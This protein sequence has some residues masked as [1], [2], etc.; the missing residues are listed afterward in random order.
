MAQ[1]LPTHRIW[2]TLFG[3]LLV[4]LFTISATGEPLNLLNPV[5]S[6][7]EE[8][9]ISKASFAPTGD[10]VIYIT[11][12]DSKGGGLVLLRDVPTGKLQCVW[13]SR[14]TAMDASFSPLGNEVAVVLSQSIAKHVQPRNLGN[15]DEY[16]VNTYSV[17]TCNPIQ[18]FKI[19]SNGVL[20]V[21]Y[22][23][24][25][26]YLVGT[27]LPRVF[28]ARLDESEKIQWIVTNPLRD[29]RWLRMFKDY[30]G[31]LALETSPGFVSIYA[32]A[33]DLRERRKSQ[34]RPRGSWP[35]AFSLIPDLSLDE[36]RLVYGS[37]IGSP[38]DWKESQAIVRDMKS[39]TETHSWSIG[40]G[41]FTRVLKF[42]PPTSKSVLSISCDGKLKVHNLRSS[43]VQY[44][45]TLDIGIC[46][47]FEATGFSS[48]GT[49]LLVAGANLQKGGS[50]STLS[51]FNTNEI[52]DRLV[53]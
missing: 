2:Q 34:V 48:D 19:K 27:K 40:K 28:F 16:L 24:D 44:G 14:G 41:P 20:S 49:K 39:L 13:D 37:S 10:A 46:P 1:K 36:Q 53:P 17:E 21:G 15:L 12:E 5:W 7:D 4:F 51:M 8:V 45:G 11:Q 52:I 9:W 23:N 25:G 30:T 32:G 38:Y 22:S 31:F 29:V 35:A 33:S 50:V 3:S 43:T 26:E 6:W 42:I 18:N 47:N